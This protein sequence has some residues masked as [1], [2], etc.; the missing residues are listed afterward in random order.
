MKRYFLVSDTHSYY[1]ELINV[2]NDN[3]FSFDNPNH[4][5][6]ILGDVFDRGEKTIELFEFLLRLIDDKKLI[7]IKGNHDY[8]LLKCF[9]NK[10]YENI[11]LVNGTITTLRKLYNHLKCRKCGE[12]IFLMNFSNKISELLMEPKI[13]KF[14]NHYIN[15]YEINNY[16]LVHSYLPIEDGSLVFKEDMNPSLWEEASWLEPYEIRIDKQLFLK[17]KIIVG[18]HRPVT[19]FN[20]RNEIFI[21]EG[22]I[23]IHSNI[24]TSKKMLCMVLEV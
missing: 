7:L 18:G 19:V 1:D 24:K 3:N 23:N 13:E 16:I 5:L 17:N 20:H 15:F 22:Y 12:S 10:E 2:L 6:V 8:Q 11:D 9:K 14:V 21:I 4:I